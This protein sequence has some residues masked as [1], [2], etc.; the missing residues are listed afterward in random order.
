MCTI[1]NVILVITTITVSFL[2]FLILFLFPFLLFFNNCA[3]QYIKICISS[4]IVYNLYDGPAIVFV[5]TIEKIG[6]GFPVIVHT[7]PNCCK[8]SRPL[9]LL[10]NQLID[11]GE[12][13]SLTH[14]PQ[15][16]SQKH[17]CYL[18]LLEADSSSGPYCQYKD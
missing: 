4:S 5:C 6:N 17:S 8:T 10:D 12:V 7:G 13:V 2:F 14:R 15:V 16:Y 18:L 9:H 3:F 11:G 1:R